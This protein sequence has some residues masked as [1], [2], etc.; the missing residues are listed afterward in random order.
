M[1]SSMLKQH[2]EI[3]LAAMLVEEALDAWNEL[4]GP[5]NSLWLQ[6]VCMNT[7]TDICI[8]VYRAH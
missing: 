2:V 8:D 4:E 1:P 5:E 6:V 3:R 7:F